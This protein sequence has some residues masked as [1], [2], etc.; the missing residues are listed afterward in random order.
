MEATPK[1][2]LAW[3]I[4]AR[5][6]MTEAQ[7]FTRVAPLLMRS[8]AL[9]RLMSAKMGMDTSS[10]TPDDWVGSFATP[11][12][13]Q[14]ILT[15]KRLY[16]NRHVRAGHQLPPW[17]LREAVVGEDGVERRLQEILVP[18]TIEVLVLGSCS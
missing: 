8:K 18:Q 2:P 11:E 3:R 1:L 17:V 13:V 10:L 15:S 16:A 14:A 6:M 12:A 9:Q 4:Q 7:L 5:F